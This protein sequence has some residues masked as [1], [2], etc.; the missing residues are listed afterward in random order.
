MIARIN[1]MALVAIFA[2]LMGFFITS[3]V[4]CPAGDDDDSSSDD[5][6]SGSD[7]DDSAAVADDDDSGE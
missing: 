4:G 6:D 7:D 5:D 2:L 1:R 3:S